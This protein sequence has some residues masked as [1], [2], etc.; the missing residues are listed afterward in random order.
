MRASAHHE[1]AA[2]VNGAIR[3]RGQKQEKKGGRKEIARVTARTAH[4]TS[5]TREQ[6]VKKLQRASDK[7][8]PKDERSE[9][10]HGA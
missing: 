3:R 10:C 7:K 8:T 6:R 2:E 1:A 9:P 4:M 5:A